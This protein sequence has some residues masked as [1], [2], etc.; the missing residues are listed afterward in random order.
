[1]AGIGLERENQI[2]EQEVIAIFS[3]LERQGLDVSGEEWTGGDRIG[4]E[5]QLL[6]E[7]GENYAKF[8]S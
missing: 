1:L 7:E 6:T 4:K 5:R 2:Q 3:G 8:E